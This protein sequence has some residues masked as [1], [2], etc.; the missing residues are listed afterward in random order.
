MI[1][2]SRW[3]VRAGW[4]FVSPLLDLIFREYGRGMTEKAPAILFDIDGTLVDSNYLH[5]A[6]WSRALDEIGTPIDS[7][8][9]HAGIGMDSSKLLDD[10][11]G[12]RKDE[13]GD[14]AKKLHSK[15]YARAADE[16]RAFDGARELVKALADDGYQVVL[17]T[18]APEDELAK[19]RKT[20]AIED[21]IALVTSDSDVEQAKPAPD[22][23]GVALDRAGVSADRAIMVGDSVWD[24]KGAGAAG[25]RCIGL[26]SG[27]TSAATLTDAGAIEVWD[28]PADLLAHLDESAISSLRP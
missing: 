11:L 16:L 21:D 14:R 17:A 3:N 23:V 28:D 24:I 25:V 1:R 8:R 7:W 4:P 13:L 10:W 18:S 22:I 2:V 15:Y 19:L 26:R 9:I 12:E 27:G 5:V 6:A 20:L